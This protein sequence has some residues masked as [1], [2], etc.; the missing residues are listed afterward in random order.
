MS[1]I[2]KPCGWTCS[3]HV[4]VFWYW[5]CLILWDVL[6]IST[7]MHYVLFNSTY[8]LSFFILDLWLGA[9]IF[10]DPDA[11]DIVFTSGADILA[12]GL[13]VTHQVVFSGIPSQ[14]QILRLKES[15]MCV[16]YEFNE[17]LF[18]LISNCLFCC[19]IKMYSVSLL[20]SSGLT[21]WKDFR[22]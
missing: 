21:C 10:G 17:H 19:L 4:T 1:K 2:D 3:G 7:P 13:N 9:Q 12:V 11:A 22:F 14:S 15:S 20:C 16:C 6:S 8:G 5:P 18:S